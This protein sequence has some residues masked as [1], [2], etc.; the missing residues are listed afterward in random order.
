MLAGL[1]S[2]LFA[3]LRLISRHPRFPTSGPLP[4]LPSLFSILPS[5]LSLSYLP[6][7]DYHI[8]AIFLVRIV[9]TN[10]SVNN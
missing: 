5:P 4:I 9:T 10:F 6:S 7:P 2:A 3:P 1:F 8:S